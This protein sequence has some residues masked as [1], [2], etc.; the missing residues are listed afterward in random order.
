MSLI[1]TE[2]KPFSATA[3]HDGEF[4][5]VSDQN[6]RG[7]WSVV[8]FYPADFTFVCP[9]ELAD[10]PVGIDSGDIYLR[11]YILVPSL[12]ENGDAFEM[13]HASV[14]YVGAHRGAYL[15]GEDVV[16]FNLD[17]DRVSMYVGTIGERIEPRPVDPADDA[18][19]V[20]PRDTWVCVRVHIHVDAVEGSVATYVGS[21]D[22]PE[23]MRAAVSGFGWR[24]R[25][26]P[27]AIGRPG[28]MGSKNQ[29]RTQEDSDVRDTV[30]SLDPRPAARSTT[31]SG[32]PAGS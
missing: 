28:E 1:N 21:D 4:V 9:T 30:D 2:V 3:Y 31:R 6:L 8:F 11:A 22:V 18:R 16:G 19:P 14:L 10:P 23:V 7:K 26:D 25:R 17:A 15:A 24:A 27:T 32:D 5:E 20:F 13:G 29:T 12:L